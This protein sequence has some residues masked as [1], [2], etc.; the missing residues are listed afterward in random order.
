MLVVTDEDGGRADPLLGDGELRAE[1]KRRLSF[2]V[3]HERRL[4]FKRERAQSDVADKRGACL[5]GT[6]LRASRCHAHPRSRSNGDR[7][8]AAGVIPAVA[9]IREEARRA[10][11]SPDR[12]SSAGPQESSADAGTTRSRPVR[13]VQQ[14]T[15]SQGL[16]ID[17]GGLPS[18][19]FLFFRPAPTPTPTPA[20]AR[21]RPRPTARA[22]LERQA[23]RAFQAPARPI[24]AVAGRVPAAGPAAAGAKHDPRLV[25]RS[26]SDPQGA[27][28]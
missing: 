11:G 14:T 1:Y 28:P 10:S 17:V 24:V 18:P 20:H 2:N 27:Q 4:T 13:P 12:T 23:R 3:E 25:A 26:S 9:A 21:P 19:P 15:R 7:S 22:R 8:R 16:L 6:C 5:P